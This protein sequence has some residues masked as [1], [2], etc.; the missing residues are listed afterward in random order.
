VSR[1]RRF[2][3]AWIERAPQARL[4]APALEGAHGNDGADD[5]CW[6]A[7]SQVMNPLLPS[8]VIARALSD[9]PQR[10]RAE[11]QR[12]HAAAEST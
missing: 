11:Y 5:L 1:R 9:D 2:A 3:G 4:H 7:P 10:A 6:L 12:D 8:A